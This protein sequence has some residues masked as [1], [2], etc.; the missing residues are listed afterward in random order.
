MNDR[1]V[2]RVLRRDFPG[3]ELLGRDIDGCLFAWLPD[4][5]PALI[6]FGED[7]PDLLFEVG[8]KAAVAEGRDWPVKC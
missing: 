3:W 5:K 8:R 7:L 4:H 1:F 2:T 6:A